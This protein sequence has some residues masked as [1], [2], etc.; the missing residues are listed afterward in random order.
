M[1]KY[2][3]PI[4]ILIM[5][6][7][8]IFFIPE[9]PMLIKILFKLIPMWLIISYAYL[10]RPSTS[11]KTYWTIICGLFFCMLGDGTLHWFIVGLSAFLIGHLFYMGAF[12]S[13][14][15][16]SWLRFVSI[17]PIVCYSFFMGKELI[18]AI[19][20]N[21][22]ASLVIP[23]IFYVI[24]ISLMTWSAIMTGNIW[25]SIGSILFVISDSI[26]SWNM[27]VANIPYSNVLIMTT[28]YLAQ[29]LIA[30]SARSIVS[31]T[32]YLDKKIGSTI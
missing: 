7:L 2:L 15:R 23:V 32:M 29:F 4:F 21:G 9:H 1:K 27:F 12:F 16:F 14:W 18:T 10:H 8:Y 20:Q 11:S 13:N 3:L 22:N 24:V 19:I 31:S 26:L 25:A 6:V 17:I 28:Y 30:H 5:S